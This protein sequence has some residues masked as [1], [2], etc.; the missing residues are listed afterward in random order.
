VNFLIHLSTRKRR[1][2]GRVYSFSPLVLVVYGYL[3]WKFYIIPT[4]TRS[5]YCYQMPPIGQCSFW[6]A[7]VNSTARLSVV[8]CAVV[9]KPTYISKVWV[10]G[11]ATC[12]SWSCNGD[13]RHEVR[14]VS[15][16]YCVIIYVNMFRFG[17]R[18]VLVSH[19]ALLAFL[20]IIGIF[21]SFW[22]FLAALY[23]LLIHVHISLVLQLP[24]HVCCDT[25]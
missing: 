17:Y 4:N 20:G 10:L 11:Q 2:D 12:D 24:M 6:G 5:A 19:S 23:I 8:V 7:R 1:H 3:V 14:L 9:Q 15:Y 22:Q 16:N 18:Y 21:G 13:A 25:R